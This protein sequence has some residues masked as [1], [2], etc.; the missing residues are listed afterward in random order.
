[1]SYILVLY[2]YAGMLAKG[3]SVTLQVIPG[4]KTEAECTAAGKASAP[5]VQ[6]SAKDLRFVCLKGGAA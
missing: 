4:F 1:M 5:L 6:G 2:I 3:D